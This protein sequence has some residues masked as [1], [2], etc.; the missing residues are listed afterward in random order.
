MSLGSAGVVNKYGDNEYD[1]PSWF[2]PMVPPEYMAALRKRHFIQ[3]DDGSYRESLSSYKELIVQLAEDDPN[4]PNTEFL[5]FETLAGKKGHCHVWQDLDLGIPGKVY[6]GSRTFLCELSPS[7]VNEN[8]LSDD[9]GNSTYTSD[10]ELKELADST[11][12]IH[13]L[14]GYALFVSV[15]L[16]CYALP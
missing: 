6:N 10:E 5:F 2:D 7:V 16:S 3:Y 11:V 14:L 1:T 8:D 13:F 9:I 4:D 15:S 12:C